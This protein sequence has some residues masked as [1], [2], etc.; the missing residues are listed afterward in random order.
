[1]QKP[2]HPFGIADAAM[3]LTAV[4]WG[5]NFVITKSAT[6]PGDDCFRIYIYNIIRFTL[7]SALLFA[8][9]RLRGENPLLNRRLLAG[10]AA[11][12]FI[13][14][15]LYQSLYMLGQTM[16]QS[17]NVGIVYGFSP[18]LILIIAIIFRFERATMPTVAGVL[19]G[20]FGL[21][22]ILFEGGARVSV[23][24]GSLLVLAAVFCWAVYA[25]FGKSVV[26]RVPPVTAMAWILLFG[27]LYQLP[28]AV[29]QLPGQSWITLSGTSILFVIMSAL[30]SLYTGYTLFYFA[31]G[32]LGP[33][34]AGIYTN[35]TPVFT[36]LFAVL[37]RGEQ[38]RMIQAAGLAV[39]IT[40]IALTKIPAR[41]MT[42]ETAAE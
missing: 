41:A 7:S 34:R 38:I 29:F 1:M 23:D 2:A 16:T 3:I 27:A 21:V 14:V 42:R 6:G 35:L 32:R 10:L 5:L 9:V 4:C 20:C 17:A 12:S 39:I 11:V 26:E 36:L 25:V 28:Q 37:I 31:V 22:M 15:Y 18:L 30:L 24:I 8:T 33:A 19:L 40:G 13:G